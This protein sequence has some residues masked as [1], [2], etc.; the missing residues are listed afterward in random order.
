VDDIANHVEGVD[1]LIVLD[2]NNLN[3]VSKI[4]EKLLTIPK[5]IT[6]DHH[7]SVPDKFTLTIIDSTISSN[8]EMIYRALDA[9]QYLTKDLAKIFLLGILED[10]GGLSY[11][12]PA[13]LGVFD[14]VKKLVEI[15][16]VNINVFRAS[17]GG[18]PKQMLPIIQMLVKNTDYKEIEG[19]PPLQYTFITDKIVKESNFS[20]EN[21]SEA[22]DI[23]TGQYLPRIKGYSWGILVTP[24]A[25][26]SSRV[27]ARSLQ[28]SVNVRDMFERMKIGGGHNT[29]SGGTFK[30]SD[31]E[32]SL[33]IIFEWMKNNKPLLN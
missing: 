15:S 18:I 27:S 7:A 4:P 13:Q 16:G 25:D 17:Y 24:K 33:D 22:K 1:L 26:G 3:R 2:V 14:I 21:L 19:W 32:K 10:T 8:S 23:F 12:G 30:D 28:G 20:D 9:E 5:T 31:P 6:I 29:A 11:V